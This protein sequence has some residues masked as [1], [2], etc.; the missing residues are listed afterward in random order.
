MAMFPMPTDRNLDTSDVMMVDAASSAASSS[1]STHHSDMGRSGATLLVP[2]VARA[3]G[4]LLLSSTPTLTPGE[5][6]SDG[7]GATAGESIQS[8]QNLNSCADQ[9]A[10]EG[11]S[12]NNTLSWH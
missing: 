4:P 10:A 7:Q 5:L 11:T 8:Y 1:G 6:G 12:A 3:E 9:L 2:I